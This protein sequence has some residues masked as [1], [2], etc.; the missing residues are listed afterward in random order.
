MFL[1]SLNGNR[2]MATVLSKGI[3]SPLLRMTIQAFKNHMMR[4]TKRV[5]SSKVVHTGGN[6][7]EFG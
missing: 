2:S 5:V 4:P 6:R 3:S 7:I 1:L